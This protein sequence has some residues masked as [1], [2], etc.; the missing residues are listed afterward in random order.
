MSFHFLPIF[1][2]SI[3]P[4]PF[5]RNTGAPGHGLSLNI[6]WLFDLT[7]S[8]IAIHGRYFVCHFPGGLAVPHLA[9]EITRRFPAYQ[10]AVGWKRAS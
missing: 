10:Q 6:D 5:W 9:R 4:H 3:P 1:Q 8:L 7:Y 2:P